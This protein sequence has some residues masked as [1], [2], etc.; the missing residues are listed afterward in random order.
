[1]FTAFKDHTKCL[2]FI[3]SFQPHNNPIRIDVMI[4][5]IIIISILQMSKIRLKDLLKV[6]RLGDGR[7]RIQTQIWLVPNPSPNL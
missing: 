2:T 6:T 7:T 3:P 4:I 5:T 1:M